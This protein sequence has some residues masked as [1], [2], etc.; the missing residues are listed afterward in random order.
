MALCC[1]WSGSMPSE[2]RHLMPA[3][4]VRGTRAKS[5]SQHSE[6]SVLNHTCFSTTS[7]EDTHVPPSQY[8]WEMGNSLAKARNSC[9]LLQH[10]NRQA[11]V[12]Q[13]RWQWVPSVCHQKSLGDPARN[14]SPF[15]SGEQKDTS[16]CLDPDPSLGQ[17]RTRV[18]LLFKVFSLGLVCQWWISTKMW[19][20][21]DPFAIL[22][23]DVG[24]TV[25]WNRPFCEPRI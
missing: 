1:W 24:E 8:H 4:M 23:R 18:G 21:H 16:K 19:W 7:T 2:R 11:R 6:D 13:I 3:G 22:A 17:I 12:Y 15:L 20:L 10:Q 25:Q 14:S 5:H 9:W